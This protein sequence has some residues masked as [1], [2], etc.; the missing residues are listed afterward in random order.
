MK[1]IV[2]G[3]DDDRRRQARPILGMDGR[4][5]RI[6]GL[7]RIGEIHPAVSLKLIAGRAKSLAHGR[8]GRI[9]RTGDG[10]KGGDEIHHR[11]NEKLRGERRAASISSPNGQGGRQ[12]AAGAI[13]GDGDVALVRP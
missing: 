1:R 11:M 3:D 12:V 4:G 13:A 9:E 2:F 10:V 5:Q 7:V 8:A 6:P